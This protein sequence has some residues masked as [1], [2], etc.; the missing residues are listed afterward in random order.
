[1]SNSDERLIDLLQQS[2]DGLL[3]MSE[4]EAPFEVFAWKVEPPMTAEM[5]LQQTHHPSDAPV[6]VVS[7]EQFFSVATEEQDWYGPEEQEQAKKYRHLVEVIKNNLSDAQV[8]K[9]GKI[10]IDVYILGR[11]ASG[12]IAG[13][14]TQVV[15]T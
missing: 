4:S 6:E 8:Y 5:V 2:V 3:C 10:K 7:L 12:Q 13:I 9:I 14:S 15:E 1:M 11:I